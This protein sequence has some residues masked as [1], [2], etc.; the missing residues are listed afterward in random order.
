MKAY[1]QYLDYDLGGL[2]TEPCGDRSVFVLDA[3]NNIDTMIQDAR[4][5]NGKR[6]PEYP[7]FQIR[8]GNF[9]ESKL[10]FTTIST[11]CPFGYE[12]GKGHGRHEECDKC[13]DDD[14]SDCCAAFCDIVTGG[15]D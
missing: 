13:P 2:L 9:R 12:F 3:R 7:H 14:Y 11:N 15:T 1:V 5:N 6:R 4:E 10:A 8:I